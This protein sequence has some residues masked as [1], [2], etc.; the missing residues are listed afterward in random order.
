MREFTGQGRTIP[1]EHIPKRH[2]DLENPITHDKVFD[3]THRR[4]HGP[5]QEM[6]MTSTNYH[7]G[8]D[9]NPALSL[10]MKGSRTID[11]ERQIM[12]QVM[13]ERAQQAAEEERMRNMRYFDSTSQSTFTEQDLTQNTLG[14]RVMRT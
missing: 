13:E 1:K 12:A 8:K 4:I 3:D 9:K 10:P 6:T 7:Y 14:K 5:Q 2:G 11:L